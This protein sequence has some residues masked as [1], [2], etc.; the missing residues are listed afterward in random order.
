MRLTSDQPSGNRP[1]RLVG[2]QWRFFEGAEKTTCDPVTTPYNGSILTMFQVIPDNLGRRYGRVASMAAVTMMLLV[3]VV[4][5]SPAAYTEPRLALLRATPLHSNGGSTALQLEGSFSLPD[6][7]QLSMPLQVLVTQ[8]ALTAR[9]DMNG[10]VFTSTNG[11]GEQPASG[12]GLVSVAAREIIVS[13]PSG[14]TAG[15]A[16]VQVIA[17]YEGRQISSNRLSVDL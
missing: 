9:F 5:T 12:P 17:I 16:T 3:S 10:G 15:A 11:G 13:L 4:S 6:V 1:R 7:V 8:G 2:Y 14:F